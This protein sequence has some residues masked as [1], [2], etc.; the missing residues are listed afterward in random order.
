MLDRRAFFGFICAALVVFA[1]SGV[2]AERYENKSGLAAGRFVWSPT[3]SSEGPLTVVVSPGQNSAHIYRNGVEIGITTLTSAG[4]E[5]SGVVLVSEIEGRIGNDAEK[6]DLVWRGQQIFTGGTPTL[7]DSRVHARLPRDFAELLMAAT[8]RGAAVIVVRERSGPQLFSAPGPFRDPLETGSTGGINRVA[9]FARPE[10]RAQLDILKDEATPSVGTE[11]RVDGSGQGAAPAITGVRGEITSLILSRADLSAYVIKDG[12][13]ADRLPI[14]VDQP[15][16]P[17]GLHTAVLMSPGDAAREARWLAFGMDEDG[18]VAHVASDN[19]ESALRRV[20][21]L[22]RG[23][24]AAVARSLRPGSVVVL[25]DGHGPS[26]TEA[27][28]LDVAVLSSEGATRQSPV[29]PEAARS[30]PAEVIEIRPSRASRSSSTSSSARSARTKAKSKAPSAR[31]RRRGP[32]DQR[33]AWPNGM[34]WP[35]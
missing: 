6:R 14:A 18:S 27:P 5:A 35:Y 21:F 32:L 12:R 4:G 8:H 30:P 34:Y 9:R 10:L 3:L 2:D 19:A 31:P 33:E 17:F 13:I 1:Y 15:T 11:K 25:M 22:D 29:L 23:R 20:R 28:H 16:R 7:A 26:V 24:S